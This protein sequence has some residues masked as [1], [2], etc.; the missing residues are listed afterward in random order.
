[1]CPELIPRTPYSSIRHLALMNLHNLTLSGL[2]TT[3]DPV[4]DTLLTLNIDYSVYGNEEENLRSLRHF[5]ALQ[6]LSCHGKILWNL[7]LLSLPPSLVFIG[8]GVPSVDNEYERGPINEI[9]ILACVLATG[10]I[11]AMRILM[12]TDYST[13]GPYQG[14][15]ETIR[16]SRFGKFTPW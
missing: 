6:W 3:L 2:L 4:K 9:L 16:V 14:Y 5:S 8:V 1:M 12:L 11:P 7:D 10:L 15:E 13:M